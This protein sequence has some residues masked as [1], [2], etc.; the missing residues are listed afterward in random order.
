MNKNPFEIRA[1]VLQMAK[2]HLDQQMSLN[3]QYI[4]RMYEIGQ[5]QLEDVKKAYTSYG[6]DELMKN[7]QEMYSFVT[8]KDKKDSG[9]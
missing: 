3:I 1:D 7:A 2:A 6:M 4:E 8:T 9:L 5:A